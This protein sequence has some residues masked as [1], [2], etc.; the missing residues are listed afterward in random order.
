LG[1][2]FISTPDEEDSLDFLVDEL[3]MMIVKVGSGEVTNIPYLRAIGKKRLPVILSTGMSTLGEVEKAIQELR[4]AGA[5]EISLLHCTTN[6]PCPMDEVNLNA[7]LT[8]REAFKTRVGYSDHTS[9][10][11]I[12]IAAVA[13]GANIIEKHFTLSRQMP[14]PDHVAS[15]EPQEIA[16]M[17]EAIR[18]VE[19]ARGSGIKGPT[20]S[21]EKLKKVVRRSL[22]ALRQIEAGEVYIEAN[23]GT[24]R[25]GG[26]G[27]PSELWDSVI[28]RKAPR[29]FAADEAIEL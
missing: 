10:I 6:Y 16:E 7:M 15:L 26:A 5:P 23:I 2:Q 11:E 12:A 25:S 17:V 8:M 14:G 20:K 29:T 1:V 19:T 22:V 28:G 3:G 27:I 13:L 21:E 9:G 24:K 18:H 4:G